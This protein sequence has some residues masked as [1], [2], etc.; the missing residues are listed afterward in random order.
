ME[1]GPADLG[2]GGAREVEADAVVA[3]LELSPGEER[4]LEEPGFLLAL[5]EGG[6]KEAVRPEP[7][8]G[9]RP[10]DPPGGSD[11]AGPRD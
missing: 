9:R 3:H 8:G 1:H 2:A 6:A 5:G 11:L 4:Q 10:G 7:D